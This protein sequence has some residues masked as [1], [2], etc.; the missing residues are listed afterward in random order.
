MAS[1]ERLAALDSRRVPSGELF[2]AEVDGRLLAATSIDTGA[3]IA[4]PFEH[5]AVDRRAAAACSP[6]P[7]ARPPALPAAVD[8]SAP[9][10][11]SPRQPERQAAARASCRPGPRALAPG[12]AQALEQ[13]IGQR[14]RAIDGDGGSHPA[15][16][17]GVAQRP[18]GDVVAGGDQRQRRD[19]RHAHARGDHAHDRAVVLGLEGDAGL[20]AGGVAGTQDHVGVDAGPAHAAHHPLVVAQVGEGD[21]AA[22]RERGG[23]RAAR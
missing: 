8:A 9:R 1:L 5:T 21:R 14:A 20:E 2:V 17:A 11:C 19:Q 4:D 3:V 10:S 6:A 12:R 15:H 23:C 13:R 7:R 16:R 22:A 18:D